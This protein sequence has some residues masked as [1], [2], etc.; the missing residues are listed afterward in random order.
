VE[1]QQLQDQIAVLR[2]QV[3]SLRQNEANLWFLDAKNGVNERQR[4]IDAVYKSKCSWED[5]G[6][7]IVELLNNEVIW[8]AVERTVRIKT[9]RAS[10]GLE[11]LIT[12]IDAM[13]VQAAENGRRNS[14]AADDGVLEPDS[15]AAHLLRRLSSDGADRLIPCRACNGAGYISSKGGADDDDSD[16]YLRRTLA[17]VLEL[18]ALLDQATDHSNEV[19]QELQTTL[20]CYAQLQGKLEQIE[21]EKRLRVEISVQV[22]LDDE[23]E[24]QV[25]NA[26]TENDGQ[27]TNWAS[28][29]T[30]K[31]KRVQLY[32]RL[33]SELKRSLTDKEA[34]IKE[35][36]GVVESSQARLVA[37]QKQSQQEQQALKREI[38]ALKTSLALSMKHRNTNIDEKQA[39]V[40]FLLKRLTSE[41]RQILMSGGAWTRRKIVFLRPR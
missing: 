31:S 16:S 39:A 32:E 19:E 29:I 20:S 8:E 33:I 11:A 27:R 22:D 34:G 5:V 13:Y 17:Q 9:V 30:R 15:K 35:L 24:E 21:A 14:S 2:H 23:D 10:R 40:K 37:L 38:S 18:K 6:G 3:E 25:L 26:I 7:S 36:R 41:Q 1:S 12:K 28:A 4:V